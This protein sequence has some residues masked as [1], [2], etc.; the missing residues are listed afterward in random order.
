MSDFTEESI[1]AELDVNK[2][3]IHDYSYL[4]NHM[5]KWLEGYLQ[6]SKMRF[7]EGCGDQNELHQEV[8]KVILNLKYYRDLDY[9]DRF[10]D[11]Q[12]T[13]KVKS[14]FVWLGDNVFKLWS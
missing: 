9:H 14:A 1:F 6:L 10:E 13:N 7:G 12:A 11:D 5:I 2:I 8:E 3:G 4:L